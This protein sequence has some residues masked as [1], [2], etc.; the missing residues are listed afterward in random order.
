MKQPTKKNHETYY[1]LACSLWA[2]G[3]IR[4]AEKMFLA[5]VQS[6]GKFYDSTYYYSSDIPGDTT[7]YTYGYGSFTSNY[8]NYAAI[9]LT[10]ISLEQKQYWKALQF[11]EDAVKRYKVTYTCGTGFYRQQD[12]YDF[13]YASCYNGLKRYTETIDRLLPSCLE[14]NDQLIITALKNTYSAADIQEALQK[15]E[16]S[17]VCT[18]DTFPSYGFITRNYGTADEKTD[19]ISYFSG[20]ATIYLFGREVNMLAPHLENGER[21]TRDMFV[22]YFME[23]AFYISLTRDAT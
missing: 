4:D 21:V 20:S 13:L 23:S 7:T 2:L 15:A 5:I 6:N 18:V 3:K 9:Y 16:S 14:R 22:K 8:K 1:A 12:E 11:L 19:T 10:K 17:I